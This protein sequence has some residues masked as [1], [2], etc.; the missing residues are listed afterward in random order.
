MI[1]PTNH[2][3]YCNLDTSE[4]ITI[5]VMVFFAALQ[6]HRDIYFSFN[7]NLMVKSLIFFFF[8]HKY[9]TKNHEC[10]ITF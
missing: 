5:M 6:Y 10:F 4:I 8:W 9:Q 7:S 1:I 2:E 3:S